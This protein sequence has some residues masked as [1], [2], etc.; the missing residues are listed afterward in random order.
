MTHFYLDT[1]YTASKFLVFARSVLR[2][3]VNV[4]GPWTHTGLVLNPCPIIVAI[5]SW[6][7]HIK[8]IK[9]MVHQ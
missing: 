2:R 8:C 6:K 7:N 1:I 9:L 5:K 3:Y 4:M